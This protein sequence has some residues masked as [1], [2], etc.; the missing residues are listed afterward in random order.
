MATFLDTED[1]TILIDPSAALGPKRFGLP[2]HKLEFEALEEAWGIITEYAMD[3]EI[4]IITHYHYDHHNRKR[5]LEIYKNK[6]LFV[7]DPINNIN[8]SQKWRA[9]AFLNKVRDLAKKIIV[10]DNSQFFVGETNILFSPPLPHGPAGTKLGFVLSVLVESSNKKFL[11]TSDVE[12]L[13]DNSHVDFIL[14]TKPH[15]IYVDGPPVYLGQKK[16]SRELLDLSVSNLIH[17]QQKLNPLIILD[18]HL[19]RDIDFRNIV[20][21]LNGFITAAEFMKKPLRLLEAKRRDL[22]KNEN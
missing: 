16:L 8:A 1:T 22:W 17:I 2:P 10:A 3:S 4:I 11:F 6:I 9:R 21:P 12:G 13:L 20:K 7:K 14:Q 15:I 18:H 19:T 5:N